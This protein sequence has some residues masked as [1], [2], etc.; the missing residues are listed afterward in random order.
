MDVES[1]APATKSSKSN[2]RAGFS[3]DSKVMEAL[4]VGIGLKTVCIVGGI[5][6]FQQV[7][8]VVVQSCWRRAG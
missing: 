2:V 4:G 3:R 1:L 8:T 7:R 6:M 5:D